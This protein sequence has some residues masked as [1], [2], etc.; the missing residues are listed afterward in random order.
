MNDKQNEFSDTNDGSLGEF[1][2]ALS[3]MTPAA[4]NVGSGEILFQAG[5]EQANRHHEA[6]RKASRTKLRLWQ[7]A[8]ACSLLVMAGSLA[9]FGNNESDNSNPEV[10]DSQV[11]STQTT[12]Q[13]SNSKPE[14][15]LGK[16][17]FD[18]YASSS[19]SLNKRQQQRQQ[20][21]SFFGVIDNPQ[22]QASQRR[23]MLFDGLA[24]LPELR[25]ALMSPVYS[26][27]SE[28]VTPNSLLEEL[29][30]KSGSGRIAPEL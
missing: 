8:T 13:K 15:T 21:M 23:R 6:I 19:N 18:M 3:V 30:P 16:V 14:Q 7:L 29:L 28:R 11:P 12:D 24:G 25:T 5:V 10:A 17:D 2:E 1:A 20:V 4:P 22:S 9:G 26:A 27:T